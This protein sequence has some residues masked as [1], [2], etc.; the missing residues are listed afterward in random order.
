MTEQSMVQAVETKG[1]GFAPILRSYYERC[2]L[3]QIIDE[4]VPLDARR[5]FLS[6]G[7]ASVAMITG[8]LF[9]VMQ[10]YRFV[11]FATETT[12]LDVVF[13]HIR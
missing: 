7:E 12:V 5:K 11:Q 1:I 9:Q 13:P 8:I 2:R 4:N 10:L 3:A 6:H